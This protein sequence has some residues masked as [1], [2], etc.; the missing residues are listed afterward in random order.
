MKLKGTL[1]AL[2]DII[3]GI[4]KPLFWIFVIKEIGK[5]YIESEY[6]QKLKMHFADAIEYRADALN[7]L[8]TII[9]VLTVLVIV[10]AVIM[11]IIV[12][13]LMK[14]KITIPAGV[15]SILFLSIIGGVLILTVYR[16]EVKKHEPV[17][18]VENRTPET[19]KI[20]EPDNVCPYCDQVIS[21]TAAVCP[22]CGGTR[23]K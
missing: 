19:K 13:V 22:Y 4:L 12:I 9:N 20:V 3:I 2:L 18:P 1:I 15:I 14:S 6:E 11:G 16:K 8:N 21:K 5:N 7:T 23:K 17:K 10:I